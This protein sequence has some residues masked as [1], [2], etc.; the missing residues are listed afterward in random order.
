ML[1]RKNLESI[2]FWLVLSGAIL[3][4]GIVTRILV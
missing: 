2:V 4:E 1:K 3:V